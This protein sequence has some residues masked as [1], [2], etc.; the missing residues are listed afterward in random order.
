[1]AA[2]DAEARSVA[3]AFGARVKWLRG[4]ADEM[5]ARN[6]AMLAGWHR[7]G[8]VAERA[9]PADGPARVWVESG[10]DLPEVP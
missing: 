4:L 5:S 6:A 1:M 9:G 10:R 7:L 2:P 3:L 8:I